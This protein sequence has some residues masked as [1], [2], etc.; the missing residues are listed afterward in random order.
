V[1]KTVQWIFFFA[2]G[3]ALG[4]CGGAA[5]DCKDGQEA[6]PCIG[7]LG[8]NIGLECRSG[9]CVN[10]NDPTTTTSAGTI[11]ASGTDGTASSTTGDTGDS[12]DSGGTPG[13]Q[14]CLEECASDEDCYIGG[15]DQGFVC[16]GSRC[17]GDTASCADDQECVA[18]YSGLVTSCSSTA[19]C[20]SQECID[21]GDPNGWCATI[22]TEFVDC[23]TINMEEVSMPLFDGTG[24]VIVCL[25]PDAFCGDMGYCERPCGNDDDCINYVGHPVCN[26]G[27]GKCECGTDSD[28]AG[29]GQP[30]WAV[31]LSGVCGCGMD[32]DCAGVT[33]ADSCYDGFCGCSD[34]S[35]CTTEPT[36]DGTTQVCDKY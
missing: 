25:A 20:P 23:A 32:D 5:G 10:P 17:V 33:N 1:F 19:D 28:C 3:A 31:C 24:D 2:A 18:L 13:G 9:Y 6:C 36:F 11:T 16:E 12:G 8:C 34:V 15:A 29:S 35:V 27:T 26:T 7:G 14:Y 30:G 4:S 22:P 21:I